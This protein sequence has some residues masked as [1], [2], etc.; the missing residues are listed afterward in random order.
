MLR[1][2]EVDEGVEAL[3]RLEHDVAALAA[4]APPAT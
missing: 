3:D 2:P 1:G 4:V